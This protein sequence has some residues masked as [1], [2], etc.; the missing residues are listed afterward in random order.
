MTIK[1]TDNSYGNISKYFHWGMF[2]ILLGLVILG[3][4]MHELPDDTPDQM[5]YKM[6]LYDM[7]KSFGILIL[8]LV[9]FRL[10]WRIINPVPKMSDSIS[11]IES[12]SA[13]AMHLL[14]YGLMFALPIFGWLMSSYA[15]FPVKIF[16][17]TLPS[18]ADKDKAMGDFFHEAHEVGAT[19]LI[20]A[21]IIHVAAALF[22]HFIRKDDVMSRMSLYKKKTE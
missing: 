10:G 8:L 12:L 16:G 4:Y 7:H 19:L 15:G 6:G 22:H 9:V 5:S 13:H 14:L 20:A 3:S 21:F 11:K 2:V 18:L 1:N 17:M